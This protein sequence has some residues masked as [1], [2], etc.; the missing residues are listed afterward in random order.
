[1]KK[2]DSFHK[3]A[4]RHMTGSHIRKI[5]ENWEYPDHRIL[6]MESGLL[7]MEEYIEKRRGTLYQYLEKNRK[8]LLER[9]KKSKRHCKEVNKILWW[10]QKHIG[11]EDS[12]N[13]TNLWFN[14]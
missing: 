2:L 5:G 3:R 6:F 8:A 12:S 14:S 1:M 10:E 9:A 4:I 13:R 11:K 7:P